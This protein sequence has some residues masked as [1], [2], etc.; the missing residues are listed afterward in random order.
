MIRR[1]K[2]TI[3][4]FFANL[5]SNGAARSKLRAQYYKGFI[6]QYPDIIVDADWRKNSQTLEGNESGAII[7]TFVR[8]ISNLPLDDNSRILLAGENI[9]AKNIYQKILNLDINQ[10]A[11]AGLDETSDF[12]WNFEQAPPKTLGKF[13]LIV[14]YAILEHLLDPYRHA[15]DLFGLLKPKAILAVYT[16]MPNFHYHRHP[17]DC[18]RFFPDWFYETAKRNNATVK[19]MYISDDH[20]VTIFVKN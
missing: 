19:K 7:G 4:N 14:S 13:D 9:C 12:D 1:F 11:I 2:K 5:V 16:V 18:M 20:I 8:A 6:T 10:I 17:V 3:G 15:C